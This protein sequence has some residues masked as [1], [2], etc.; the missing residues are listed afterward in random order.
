M[1]RLKELRKRNCWTQKYTAKQF[2]CGVRTIEAWEQGRI[3]ISKP[4]NIILTL[5]EKQPKPTLNEYQINTILDKVP[6]YSID[7][8]AMLDDCAIIYIGKKK[9]KIDQEGKIIN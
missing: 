2:G 7:Q 4:A 3:H 1:Q 8:V 5:L 6:G 9:I